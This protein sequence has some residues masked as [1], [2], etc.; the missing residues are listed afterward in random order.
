MTIDKFKALVGDLHR[1]AVI[2]MGGISASVAAI[3]C[4]WKG[5]DLLGAAA[6]Q[7]AIWAGVGAMYWG[8]AWE[9]TRTPAA[10]V[11]PSSHPPAGGGL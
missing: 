8:R 6:L 5:V 1:P 2:L 7:A 10:Q 4:A 9:N 3:I 11:P